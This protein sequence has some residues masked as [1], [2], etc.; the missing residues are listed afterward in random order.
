[1]QIKRVDEASFQRRQFGVLEDYLADKEHGAARQ[2]F[3]NSLGDDECL[4]LVSKNG[5]NLLF[6]RG[7]NTVV[8]DGVEHK[9]LGFYQ[10]QLDH[11][12]SLPMI[13]HFAR[14]ARMPFRITNFKTFE[15]V[16]PKIAEGAK[17]FVRKAAA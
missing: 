13:Q 3:I 8:L 17:V 4:V 9:G 5:M 12:W 16:F 15:Q 6:V 7:F 1:M 2:R 11:K 10:M 14:D